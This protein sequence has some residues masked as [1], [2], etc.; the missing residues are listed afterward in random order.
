[1]KIYID[2]DSTLYDTNKL[3]KEFIN[4]FKRNNIKE[5]QIKE[6]MKSKEYIKTKSFDILAN[7]IIKKYNLNKEIYNEIDKIYSQDLVFK[8]V[9][10]FLEKYYQ[11]YDLILLT[12]GTKKFQEKKIK[13]SNLNKYFKDIIIT[14]K[15]KSKLNIDYINGV[16]I[17]NNPNE[18]KKFYNS[19][20][21]KLIRI[22]RDTDKYSKLNLNINNIPE[23]ISFEELEK[24][25]YLEKI[26]EIKHE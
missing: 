21:T 15:D 7:I 20:A 18:L 12:F 19:K 16:F 1:M 14:N 2:F 11:K 17:D 9:I 10:P 24:N 6:L 8:D 22:K 3:Y 23:F 25:N 13:S 4:I 26:G 5:I